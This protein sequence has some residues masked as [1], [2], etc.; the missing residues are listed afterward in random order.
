[1]EPRYGQEEGQD[2]VEYALVLPLF[3]FLVLSIIELSL[4]FFD[5]VTVSNAAREGARAGVVVAS[6]ACDAGCVDDI[7]ETAAGRLTTGLLP[8]RLDVFIRH[9]DVDIIEVEVRYQ[10]PLLTRMIFEVLGGTGSVEISST[11]TM[12]KEG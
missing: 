7:A 8:D 6:D 3:F 11:A 12:V 9:P 4:L 2:L 10:A 5:F 1:M